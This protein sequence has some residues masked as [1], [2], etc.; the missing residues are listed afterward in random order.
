MVEELA[1]LR[2]WG[3]AILGL[4]L[5]VDEEGQNYTKETERFT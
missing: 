5:S 4:G 3:I 1:F 2:K